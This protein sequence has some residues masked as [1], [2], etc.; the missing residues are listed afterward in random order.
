I[1]NFEKHRK[2][3]LFSGKFNHS[4]SEIKFNNINKLTFRANLNHGNQISNLSGQI[5]FYHKG[6]KVKSFPLLV[7]KNE[8]D[9]DLYFE[10]KELQ[11]YD[12]FRVLLNLNEVDKSDSLLLN[13]SFYELTY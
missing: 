7:D 12:S 13:Y 6:D 5:F 4:P 2:L 11:D 3:K 1:K 9:T 8:T 10:S